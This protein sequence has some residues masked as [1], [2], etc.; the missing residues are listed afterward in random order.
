[1]ESGA[2]WPERR[3]AHLRGMKRRF[4]RR[5]G[6]IPDDTAMKIDLGRHS[7]AI[8][9][10]HLERSRGRAEIRLGCNRAGETV[11]RG[12]Y[13][14]SPCRVLFPRPEIG[15]VVTAVVATT[16]GGLTG[17]DRTELNVVGTSGSRALVTTQAAE[18]I[19]R[20]VAVNCTVTMTV[21][22]AEDT[23][24]EWLP[25]ETILFDGARLRR[26]AEVDVAADGRFLAC[27]MLVFGRRARGERFARGFLHDSW[28]VRRDGHLLWADDLRLDGDICTKIDHPVGFA[29]AGAYATIVYVGM[30]GADWVEPIRARIAEACYPATVRAA[31]SLVKGV[32]VVRLFGIEVRMLRGEVMRLCV[33]LRTQIA[34][35]PAR[36]PRVWTI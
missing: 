14:G 34:G 19:Y 3:V 29:G 28:R 16:A 23:W 30:D 15:E 36:M 17:G 25:Q 2:T 21:T 22:A 11:I 12:L 8:P 32:L 1:M 6:S 4:D 26:R 31:A 9:E 35:L 27:D 33:F 5:H 24:L 13:Q 7:I 18:K 20:A 10:S